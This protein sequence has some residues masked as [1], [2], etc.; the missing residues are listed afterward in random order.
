MARLRY[1]LEE[2]RAKATALALEFAA[3]Q[4]WGQLARCA[5]ANP[6]WVRQGTS[7]KHPT[8]WSVC[9]VFNPSDVVMDGGEI[10]VD[11]DLETEVVQNH[12][13]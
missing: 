6:S 10:F 7:S 1:T 2:A 12:N 4:A 9:F 8:V 13:W 5:S 3:G 11:V